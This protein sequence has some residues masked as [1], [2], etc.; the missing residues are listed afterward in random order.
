[1]TT[2]QALQ[3]STTNAGQFLGKKL[4]VNKGDEANL[5]I[6]Q[7]S[8]IEDISNTQKVAFVIHHGKVI[9]SFLSQ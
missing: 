7:A 6:L 3:A 4:G 2:W 5:V 8:P 9:Q 1:M